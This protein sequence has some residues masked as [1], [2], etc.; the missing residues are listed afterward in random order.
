[1]SPALTR[2]LE[3][4][5]A[6]AAILVAAIVVL[7]LL[8]WFLRRRNTPDQKERRRRLRV[9]RQGRLISGVVMDIDEAEPADGDESRRLVHYTYR[10][11]GV[12]Y[13]ACQDVTTLPDALGDDPS[14]IIGAVQ[15]KV[16]Q[17]NPYNSIVVC[18][19]WSGFRGTRL[20]Q[21]SPEA[22]P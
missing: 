22:R 19:D 5:T 3:S 2:F 8:I 20:R 15:V 1:M 4:G 18:E 16:H 11:G 7:F 14:L 13:S 10:I 12:E 17:S 9:N 21:S 6:F